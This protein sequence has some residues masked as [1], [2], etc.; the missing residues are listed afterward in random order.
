M[1]VRLHESNTQ[2]TQACEQAQ[3]KPLRHRQ[4][5][6]NIGVPQMVQHHIPRVHTRSHRR[7]F[8]RERRDAQG[9]TLA[10][11]RGEGGVEHVQAAHAQARV[12]NF[13]LAVGNA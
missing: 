1:H 7:F 8:G 6:A 2:F 3:K 12:H 13:E 11:P 5:P 10:V 4:S 9:K